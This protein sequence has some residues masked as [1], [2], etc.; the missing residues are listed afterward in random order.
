LIHYY[1][2]TFLA[3]VLAFATIMD[4]TRFTLRTT[5]IIF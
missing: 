4:K 5:R 2:S 1:I 3:Y